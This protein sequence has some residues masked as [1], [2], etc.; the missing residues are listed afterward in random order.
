MTYMKA[1]HMTTCPGLDRFIVFNP[2][3]P[4]EGQATLTRALCFYDQIP[5][6]FRDQGV[7]QAREA[8]EG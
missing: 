7:T 4:L 6:V 1:S 5:D 3:H 2:G 8:L